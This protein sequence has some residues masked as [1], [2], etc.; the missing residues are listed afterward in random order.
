[1]PLKKDRF[2][3]SINSR[4]SKTPTLGTTILKDVKKEYKLTQF[5][6]EKSSI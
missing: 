4:E 2:Y 5:V 3:L 1:M 6:F